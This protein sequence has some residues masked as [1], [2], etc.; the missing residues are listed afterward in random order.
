MPRL[1]PNAEKTA[2]DP[3]WPPLLTISP[4]AS[5]ISVGQLPRTRGRGVDASAQG[6]VRR[7]ERAERGRRREPAQRRT[8]RDLDRRVAPAVAGGEI[9]QRARRTASG[10]L[11]QLQLDAGPDAQGRV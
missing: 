2:L 1:A 4:C 8:S 10:H 3:E 7:G 5:P 6:E 9:T 11:V